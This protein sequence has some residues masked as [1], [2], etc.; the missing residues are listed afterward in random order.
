VSYKTPTSL[1]VAIVCYHTTVPELRTLLV[2]LHAAIRALS[3]LLELPVT[4]VYLIDN[5]ELQEW[6]LAALA[7]EGE[8]LLSVN[9]ELHFLHG[10]GNVGYGSAHNVVLDEN[11]LAAGLQH[12]LAHP[13]T[14]IVSPS[15][16]DISGNTQYLCK[17]YPAVFTFLIRG[18]F[19]QFLKRLFVRRLA[20]FEMQ[21]LSDQAPTENIAIVSGCFMLCRTENLRRAQGFDEGYFLYFEDFDL[22]LRMQQLGNITYVPTMRIMH[23][24]G[25]AAK[26]GLRH[27]RMFAKSGFRFYNK[28]GW[29]LFRQD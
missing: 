2:S 14:A 13:G 17:T 4:H 26:K 12:L 20:R 11:C 23:A 15:A 6:T 10:H 21:N 1:S 7:A 22:S 27:L 3:S 28:H 19:P 5:S 18:F 24:G 25:H 29:R 9:T 16:V 8:L